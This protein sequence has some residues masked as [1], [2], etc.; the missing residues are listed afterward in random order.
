[1][2]N[3]ILSTT[4]VSLF[5]KKSAKRLKKPK[6]TKLLKYVDCH[7]KVINIC[8]HNSILFNERIMMAITREDDF[9]SRGEGE[10]RN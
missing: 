10:W 6:I 4:V 9:V 2:Y 7:V 5:K 3:F 8:L 1:M